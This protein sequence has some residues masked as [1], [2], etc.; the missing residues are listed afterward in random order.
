MCFFFIS[1]PASYFVALPLGLGLDGLWYGYGIGLFI[2][3]L[4][5]IGL[6]ATVNWHEKALEIQE[7]LERQLEQYDNYNKV[8][9][10]ESLLSIK[11][12]HDNDCFFQQ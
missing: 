9:E 10:G 1:L 7:D 5:Y 3:N 12:E 8:S 6:I 2:L 11:V 4:L